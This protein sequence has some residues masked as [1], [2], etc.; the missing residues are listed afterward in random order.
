MV[1][2]NSSSNRI[3]SPLD[4]ARCDRRTGV[5]FLEQVDRP[6]LLIHI[7]GQKFAVDNTQGRLDGFA[8]DLALILRFQIETVERPDLSGPDRC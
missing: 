8:K 4:A 6:H 3:R 2:N 5:F 7:Q 1:N